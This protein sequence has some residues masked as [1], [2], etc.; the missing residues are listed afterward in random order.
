MKILI[1][2]LAS[3]TALF[4]TAMSSQQ[5]IKT[6]NSADTI[7]PI[8]KAKF[9]S[10][11]KTIDSSKYQKDIL[12]PKSVSCSWGTYLIISNQYILRINSEL[13]SNRLEN[14][15]ELNI[16][17][18]TNRKFAELLVYDKLD[19]TLDNICTDIVHLNNPRE[20]RYIVPQ[21]GQLLIGFTKPA[22]SFDQFDVSV[23][24][25][26]L[27]FTDPQTKQIIILKNEVIWKT[28]YEG[29]PG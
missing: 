22:N 27:T 16:D 29:I 26:N 18:S 1:I 4:H 20:N 2:I 6:V 24:I 10:F 21:K 23:L 9:K 8:T 11:F 7:T 25:R 28:I 19:A 5:V 13:F 15:Y 17:S 14:Y 3:F 12:H